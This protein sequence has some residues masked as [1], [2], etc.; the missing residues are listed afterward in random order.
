MKSRSSASTRPRP[1]PRTWSSPRT[2]TSWPP[3]SPAAGPPPS[4]PT[5][6]TWPTSPPSSSSPRRAAAVES[7][8]AGTAG[9]AN[10]LALGYKAHLTDRGLAP[11][12]VARRLAALRS[13]VKLARTLGRV[14]WAID[15]PSPRAEAYRDTRGPGLEGWKSLLAAARKRATTPKG[16]RDLA[17]VRLMHDLGLRRGEVVALDLADL[18]LEAGHGGD[19]RQGEV[20]EDERD[21]QRPDGGGAGRLGRGPGRV[22]GAAVRPARPGRRAGPPDPAGR[23]QRGAGLA[24]R[25]GCG[26]GWPGAPTPTGCGTRGSPGRWTWPTGTCGR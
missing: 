2:A 22:A 13:V 11:A 23:G 25:W 14:A 20:G 15:I 19:R 6:R 9:R 26:P 8:V 10:T 3:S 12:T 5:P 24:R 7:L 17:L 21:A 4:G 1:R 16:K 18:D